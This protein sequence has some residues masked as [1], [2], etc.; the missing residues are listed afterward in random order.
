[1]GI[2]LDWSFV[3]VEIATFTRVCTYDRAGLGWSDPV[4]SPLQSS[5]VAVSLNT[6][7][8]NAGVQGPYV[9]VGHSIGGIHV[10]S[11][12]SQ[13]PHDVA[14]I[15]LVDSSHENQNHRFPTEL[16][17][18]DDPTTSLLKICRFVAPFGLMRLL[19]IAESY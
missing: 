16:V 1:M 19:N 2:S 13:Y 8:N 17:E 15:I 11:F 3:H 6:L 7:L 18:V 12:A 10:R 9:L 4:N 5:Q 14:G